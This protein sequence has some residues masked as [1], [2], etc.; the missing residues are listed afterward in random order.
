[1]VDNTADETSILE[2]LFLLLF[3]TPQIGKSVDNDTKNQ[4]QYND[5]NDEEEQQ[6]VNHAR[7]KHWL[8]REK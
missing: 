5:D 6:V 3:L 7:Y 1:V 2:N 4:I 8:L